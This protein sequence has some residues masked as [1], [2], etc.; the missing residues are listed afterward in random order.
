[1]ASRRFQ[2]LCLLTLAA[3]TVPAAAN[4]VQP[5]SGRSVSFDHKTGNEWWVEVLI[6]GPDASRVTR[7]EGIDTDGVWTTMPKQ[8]WGAYAASFHIEP[9]NQVRFRATFSDGV[10]TVSCWFDHPSGVERCGVPLA[11]GWR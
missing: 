11:S 5:E 9:G 2:V 4:H 7:V 3:L 8:S 10:Q 6:G 1:M